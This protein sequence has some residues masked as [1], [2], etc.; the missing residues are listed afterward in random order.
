MN[1]QNQLKKN[2]N[3]LKKNDPQLYEVVIQAKE[4]PFC[5]SQSG[6]LNLALEDTLI[7]SIVDPIKEAKE[8]RNQQNLNDVD[9][10]FIYGIGLGY[11]YDALRDWLSQS[12]SRYIVFLEDDLN[13]LRSFLATEKATTILNDPQVYIHHLREPVKEQQFKFLAYYFSFTA[14]GW[15]VLENYTIKKANQAKFLRDFIHS[16]FFR[17][18]ESFKESLLGEVFYSNLYTNM[19][20]LPKALRASGLFGMY[21]N[22]PAIICGA[23]PSLG[24]NIDQ[25]VELQDKALIFTG[26]TGVNALMN[27][28]IYPHFLAYLDPNYSQTERFLN[29]NSFEVPFFYYNRVHCDTLNGLHSQKLFLGGCSFNV[30]GDYLEKKFGVFDK[31]I[32]S[33]GSVLSW[34]LLIAKYMG[35]NPIIFVGMD[36]ALTG[37]GRY[38]RGIWSENIA[39]KCKEISKSTRYSWKDIY[40]NHTYT[41]DSF[42]IERDIISNLVK[43]CPE[44]TFIN[45]TEG[46]IGADGVPNILL[47]EVVRTFLQRPIDFNGLTHVDI[48]RLDHLKV[49]SGEIKNTLNELRTKF[50]FIDKLSKEITEIVNLDNIS[51]GSILEKTEFLERKLQTEDMYKLAIEDVLLM[52]DWSV[53]RKKDELQRDL[54]LTNKQKTYQCAKFHKT[55]MEYVNTLVKG[56]LVG[57]DKAMEKSS[58]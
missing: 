28:T 10:L 58:E 8:W 56:H 14:I 2:L 21:H 50:K 46:G 16:I 24:K 27:K 18:T 34:L 12:V 38:S 6:H 17:C 45:A 1:K 19:L 54:S 51:S 40:G 33:A 29:N 32:P 57:S 43:K 3:L 42:V 11:Y 4:L 53:K 44:T 7:H 49:T 30:I 13:V 9:V 5:W 20:H 23:G 31:R 41:Q 35:C 52:Y 48:Q 37:G 47:K 55:K 26:C 39:K 22:V 25:L 36:L 15:G